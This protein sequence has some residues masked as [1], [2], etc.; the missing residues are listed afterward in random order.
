MENNC[1]NHVGSRTFSQVRIDGLVD[2]VVFF[3]QNQNDV[4][5]N[6]EI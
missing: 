2:P 4:K 6:D 1:Y 3:S 5:Y